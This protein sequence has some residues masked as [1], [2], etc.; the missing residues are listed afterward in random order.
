MKEAKQFSDDTDKKQVYKI[1]GHEAEGR[2][3]F[4]KNTYLASKVFI[5][6]CI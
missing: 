1:S 3:P 6:M 5:F 4:E 2:V